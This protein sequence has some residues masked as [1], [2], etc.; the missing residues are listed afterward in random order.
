MNVSGIQFLRPDFGT[1]VGRTLRTHGLYGDAL[2]FEIT[3]SAFVSRTAEVAA[4]LQQLRALRL[5][6]SIDDFGTGYSSLAYL[7]RI[8]ADTLT[9]DRSFYPPSLF[10]ASRAA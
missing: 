7:Q 9:I 10:I 8:E 6:P 1:E 2:R 4:M 5:S 3:E